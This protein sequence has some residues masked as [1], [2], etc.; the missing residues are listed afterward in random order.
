MKHFAA[1]YMQNVKEGDRLGLCAACYFL[2]AS[3]RCVWYSILVR[4]LW[5]S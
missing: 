3:T 1:A 5:I 2:V 4:W